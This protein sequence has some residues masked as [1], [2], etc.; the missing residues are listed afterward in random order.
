MGTGEAGRYGRALAAGVAIAF[1]MF[2]AAPWLPLSYA[3][4]IGL[5]VAAAVLYRG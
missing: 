5:F 3:L 4:A 1:V 2:V